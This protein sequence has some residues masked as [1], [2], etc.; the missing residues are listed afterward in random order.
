M[1]ALQLLKFTLWIGRSLDFTL[2]L[3]YADEL[4]EMEKGQS[5]GNDVPKDITSFI[6]S[7]SP[8]SW[9]VASAS[10]LSFLFLSNFVPY[11]SY[12]PAL[13]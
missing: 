3:S 6:Q 4:D 5:K 7:L 10:N 12:M 1:E 9:F 13:G 11:I 8:I 2:G